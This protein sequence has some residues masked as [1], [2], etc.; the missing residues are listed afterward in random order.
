MCRS[1]GSTNKTNF[2]YRVYSNSTEGVRYYFTRQEIA[3][4]Y[5]VS[6][7]LIRRK[8]IDPSHVGYCKSMND[9]EIT[10]CKKPAYEPTL[11]KYDD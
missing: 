10:R 6:V 2:H 8:L 1:K 11:I 3:D 4:D 7:S 5:G 9:V